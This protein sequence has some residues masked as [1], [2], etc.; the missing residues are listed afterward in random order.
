MVNLIR[1]EPAMSCISTALADS[2]INLDYFSSVNPGNNPSVEAAISSV[3][4]PP[5]PC[6][7]GCTRI[8]LERLVDIPLFQVPAKPWTDASDSDDHVSHLISLYFTWDH[9]CCQLV[10]QT[11]FLRDVKSGDLNSE[12]CTPFLVNIILAMASVCSPRFPGWAL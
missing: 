1:S 11:V 7:D 2:T 8:T 9:P 5:G 3:L 4:P 6:V 12:Y 10:D